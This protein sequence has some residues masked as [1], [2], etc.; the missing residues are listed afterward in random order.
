MSFKT[1]NDEVAQH[2][3]EFVQ[4]EDSY[5][6]VRELNLFLSHKLAPVEVTTIVDDPLPPPDTGEAQEEVSLPPVGIRVASVDVDDCK[7]PHRL[8][9]SPPHVFEIRDDEVWFM[10][11]LTQ[12]NNY[13]VRVRAIGP[14]DDVLNVQSFPFS[15]T[16]CDS[17]E[18]CV[19]IDD[20]RPEDPTLTPPTL[21][22]S[23]DGCVVDGEEQTYVNH[24]FSVTTNESNVIFDV[25]TSRGNTYSL[26]EENLMGVTPATY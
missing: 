8:T 10:G 4:N 2:R 11:D 20:D 13:Q 22:V 24:L 17:S 9:V 25:Q 7:A 12:E 16:D 23:D 21:N 14:N 18:P 26:I 15:I 5:S 19:V 3:I 6:E 1:T